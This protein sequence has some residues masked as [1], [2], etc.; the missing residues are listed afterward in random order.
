[1]PIASAP[2]AEVPEDSAVK[3]GQTYGGKVLKVVHTGAYDGLPAT[4]DKIE[5]YLAAHGLEAAGHPWDQWVSDPDDTPEDEL[6]THIYHPLG[7]PESKP[8]A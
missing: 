6:I 1:M 4:Y 8:S 2:D 5:A 7:A 3:I